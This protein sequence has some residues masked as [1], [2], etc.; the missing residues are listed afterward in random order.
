MIRQ[1]LNYLFGDLLK[2]VARVRLTGIS[3]G[4][5]WDEVDR[6]SISFVALARE[7][8]GY[9]PRRATPGEDV[10]L[11]SEALIPPA[12]RLQK[13]N[14]SQSVWRAPLVLI[15]C[16]FNKYSALLLLP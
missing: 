9:V 12:L 8:N 3:A 2:T 4:D 13:D 5:W 15:S 11:F 16:R 1:N 10:T 14:G 7:V 6:N